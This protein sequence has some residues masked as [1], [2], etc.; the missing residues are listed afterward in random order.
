MGN[1]QSFA[2]GQPSDKPQAQPG[3][4]VNKYLGPE[5]EWHEHGFESEKEMNQAFQDPRYETEQEF[6]DAVQ[7]MIYHSHPST[8]QP[9]VVSGAELNR[10]MADPAG[11]RA[12]QDQEIYQEKVLAMFSDER[13][14]RSPS[15][16]REVEDFI[17]ANDAMI[18][19]ALGHRVKDRNLTKGVHHVQLHAEDAASVRKSLDEER[20]AKIE[21]EKKD[22][23]ARAEAYAKQSSADVLGTPLG[24]EDGQ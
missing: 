17:R 5:A 20:L 9:S 21:S 23:I 19:K 14:S 6:R 22:A 24:D 13:Y 16:R 3:K 1:F 2:V 12:L 7:I 4:R 15:Y 10:A 8:D 18:D 11:A